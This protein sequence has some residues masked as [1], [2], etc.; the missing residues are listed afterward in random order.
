M[1]QLAHVPT[2]M[3]LFMLPK[4]PYLKI[5]IVKYSLSQKERGGDG[6]AGNGAK[7][8]GWGCWS[9]LMREGQIPHPAPVLH[10]GVAAVAPGAH[11]EPCTVHSQQPWPGGESHDW[12]FRRSPCIHGCASSPMLH[13]AFKALQHL[14]HQPMAS[15]PFL[16]HQYYPEIAVWMYTSAFLGLGALQKGLEPVPHPSHTITGPLNLDR[17]SLKPKVVSFLV[18]SWELKFPFVWDFSNKPRTCIHPH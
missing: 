13:F 12:F 17:T 8:P 1:P 10:H 16:V 15:P 3:H 2:R 7:C 14:R 11:T 4:L 5:I 9:V 18:R 6:W